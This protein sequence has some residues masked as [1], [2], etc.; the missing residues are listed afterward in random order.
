M[1]KIVAS[2]AALIAAVSGFFVISG[3]KID[4]LD[5][6]KLVRQENGA[7]VDPGGWPD[8]SP[9]P[10]ANPGETIRVATFNIQVFGTSKSQKPAVMDIL[11]RIVRQFD[12]VAVQEIRAIDQDI[13]PNFVELIN[14]PGLYYDYVI[15]PRLGRTVSKEQYAFIFNQATIEV[16]RQQLYT[17]NDPEDLLH[18]E[19][20]VGW[21]RARGPAP[22]QAF[23]FSLINIHTDP[24]ETDQELDILDDVFRVVQRD[25]RGEDDVILLGDLNVDDRHL[26]QLGQVS[27]ITWTISGVP[28][29]TRGTAQY[30]N[31]LF[32]SRA[33]QEFTGRA[34]VFDFMRQY[35]LTIDEAN[36]VSDHLPIWAEFSVFEGGRIGQVATRPTDVPR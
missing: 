24:D 4:G 3:Y 36:E 30:D 11:A 18:R 13:L 35:N 31:I 5:Q 10:P 21:F 19:P 14:A 33:T 8:G 2:L 27:G 34:G 12:I 20:L 25:G 22:E 1:R 26:G 6:I 16:D 9:P 7:P 17:V 23:T 15:G 29:N 28:T 32:D